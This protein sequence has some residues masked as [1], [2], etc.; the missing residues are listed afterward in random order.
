MGEHKTKGEVME[1]IIKTQLKDQLAIVTFNRPEVKNAFN[2]A[3]WKALPRTLT[4]LSENPEIRAVVLKGEGG[5]FGAGADIKEL[6][7]YSS[8]IEKANNYSEA[9][10]RCFL[11][12]SQLPIP[13]IA[14]IEGYA[15]GG[16][17]MVALSC[18]IRVAT[19]KAV[20]GIPLPRLGLA[21][22]WLG[23]AKLVE[24]VGAG[25][26]REFLLTADPIP[27]ERLERAGMINAIVKEEELMETAF[28]FA[29]RIMKNSPN[30]IRMTRAVLNEL[31]STAPNIAFLNSVFGACLFHKD[32]SEG[33]T[34]FIEKRKPNW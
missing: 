26:A 32:F 1:E 18:D 33:A 28:S 27:L 15:L 8:S 21:V 24:T 16:G 7:E 31:S 2:L 6:V 30:A 5:H 20:L 34:A 22:E 23:I 11:T 19:E 10:H 9:V 14:A 25:Y 3:L 13:L 4:A 12:M 29:K 17:F